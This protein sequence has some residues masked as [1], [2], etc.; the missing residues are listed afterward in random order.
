MSA[1]VLIYKLNHCRMKKM[2]VRKCSQTT[3]FGVFGQQ[4]LVHVQIKRRSISAASCGC[5]MPVAASIS[6]KYSR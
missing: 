2:H 5:S 4:E 6:T 1:K 3:V